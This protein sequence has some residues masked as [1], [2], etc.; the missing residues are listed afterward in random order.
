MSY[1][2]KVDTFVGGVQDDLFGWQATTKDTPI[3]RSEAVAAPKGKKGKEQPTQLELIEGMASPQKLW[4][5]E[6]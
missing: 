3:T 1:N 5:R 4:T 2:Q 6:G